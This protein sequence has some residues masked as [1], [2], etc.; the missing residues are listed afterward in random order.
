[1]GLVS[2]TLDFIIHLTRLSAPEDFIE[3]CRHKNYKTYIDGALGC[4]IKPCRSDQTER[5]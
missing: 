4:N 5:S 2:E 3:F 1:M